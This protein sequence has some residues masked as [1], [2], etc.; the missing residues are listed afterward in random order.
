MK[1]KYNSEQVRMKYFI[2]DGIYEIDVKYY[3]VFTRIWDNSMRLIKS[4]MYSRHTLD[5]PVLLPDVEVL[6]NCK[7]TLN[8]PHKFKFRGTYTAEAL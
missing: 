2:C 5:A 3:W 7:I 8:A 6:L 4:F 1:I